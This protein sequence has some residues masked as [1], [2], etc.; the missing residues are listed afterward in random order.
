M[1][2]RVTTVGVD[3]DGV[4]PPGRVRE[5]VEPKTA[6]V[7]VMWANNEVG[8]VQPVAE[9]AQ[10]ARERGALF[11]T[12]AVQA[13]RYEPVDAGV[14]DL[15]AF[16]A[17]KVGGPKGV[18]ALVVRRGTKLEPLL[19]GGGQE[20]GLRSSTYNV[21]GIAGFGAAVQAT[22]AERDTVVP[23]VAALRDALQAKLIA[24]VS[25]VHVNG[26][27]ASRLAGHLNVCIEGIEGEPLILLLDAAGIAVSSGSACTSGSTE[28]S[29]V[30]VAMGVPRALAAGSL[31]LTLGPQT[32]EADVDTAV[33]AVAE[34]VGRLRR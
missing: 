5:A 17:H 2:F 20:R 8:T 27:G 9:L 4:V 6:I 28:P 13:L 16:S 30:L 7:S 31:R 15:V 14:A 33:A 1:G 23:R 10:I 3:G 12:D 25:G 11:H 18:G 26:A 32:T 24:A 29:H 19:H 22:A 21:A 34:A